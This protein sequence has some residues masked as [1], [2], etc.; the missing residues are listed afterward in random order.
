M[1]ACQVEKCGASEVVEVGPAKGVQYRQQA[2]SRFRTRLHPPL[3]Q[4]M[5]DELFHI[6]GQGVCL[7]K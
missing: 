2:E 7:C 1:S 4:E 6:S 5:D 3:G